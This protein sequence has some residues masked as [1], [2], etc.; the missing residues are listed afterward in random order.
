MKSSQYVYT[1]PECSHEI[2]C[3][4][5]PARPAPPCS[6]HDSP[7]FSDSGD[8]AELDIPEECPACGEAIDQDAALE[9]AQ[10]IADNTP[11]PSES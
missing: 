2:T 10:N 4:F 1:C 11:D 8:S 5:T 9:D 3:P 6:N 7:A